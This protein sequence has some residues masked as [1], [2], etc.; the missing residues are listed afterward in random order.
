MAYIDSNSKYPFDIFKIIK[1]SDSQL[2][3]KNIQHLKYQHLNFVP[4]ESKTKSKSQNDVGQV[5]VE[6]QRQVETEQGHVDVGKKKKKV[7]ISRPLKKERKKDATKR[8][9]AF[10]VFLSRNKKLSLKRRSNGDILLRFQDHIMIIKFEE[11]KL[12]QEI[13]FS[14]YCKRNILERFR[15]K[16]KRLVQIFFD[17]SQIKQI[18]NVHILKYVI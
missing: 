5:D 11:C 7:G 15:E 18:N 1:Y 14:K 17:K 16:L 6:T 13:L 8:P 10:Y 4:N 12:Y 2:Q 3:L 9:T